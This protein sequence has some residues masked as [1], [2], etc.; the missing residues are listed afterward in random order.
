LLVES[1]KWSPPLECF[2][3]TRKPQDVSPAKRQHALRLFRVSTSIIAA[4]INHRA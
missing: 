3:N 2:M 4:W 1:A